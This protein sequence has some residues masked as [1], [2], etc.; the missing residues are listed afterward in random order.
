MNQEQPLEI[1]SEMR[2][3]VDELQTLILMRYPGAQFALQP[4]PDDPDI[5]HLVATV[6]AENLDD[7]LDGVVDRMM[8]M[9]IDEALPIYVIP[10]RPV[11]RPTQRT[12]RLNRG[13]VR[14][15]VHGQALIEEP[16][17]TS[18]P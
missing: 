17:G 1:S 13:Q 18:R 4:S 6:D 16:S 14:N 12:G 9:Q 7:V 3:A 2:A 15:S 11:D 8:E 10:L 5:V